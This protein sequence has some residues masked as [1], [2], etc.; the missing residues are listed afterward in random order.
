MPV[1]F[2]SSKDAAALPIFRDVKPDVMRELM[3]SAHTAQYQKGAIFLVQSEPV[4][5]FYVMLEGWCGAKKGN[6]EGQEAILQ[7][8]RRG[9]F[10]LEAG[11]AVLADISPMNLQALTPVQLLALSPAAVRNALERSADFT[12]NMLAASVRRCQELRDHIEHLTLHNAERRVG[13]FLLHMRF[14]TNPEGNDIVL[15]FDKSLIAAYLGIKP[16]TLSRTLLAFRKRGFTVERSH[17]TVP[18]RTALCAYCDTITMQ[19]CPF[20]CAGDCPNAA[21]HTAERGDTL[22]GLP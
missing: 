14:Y 17:M 10:L 6:A 12:T 5:R 7:I 1:V 2:N 9:D 4:S 21:R 19:S 13:R 15:P 3:A 11:H 18:S 20:A 16:E 8:F 22:K